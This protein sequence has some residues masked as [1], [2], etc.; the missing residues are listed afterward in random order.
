MAYRYRVYTGP[1]ALD[2]YAERL[3]E[4][5]ATDV[6]KGT[7]HVHFTSDLPTLPEVQDL[8]IGMGLSHRTLNVLRKV[9]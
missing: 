8:V 6:L 2:H 9:N 5:G 4:A 1:I 3:T 7:E